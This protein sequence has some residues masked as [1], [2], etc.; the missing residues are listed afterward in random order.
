MISKIV[1]GLPLGGYTDKKI[2]KLRKKH[3]EISPVDIKKRYHEFKIETKV[4]RKIEKISHI[5]DG[6]F[7]DKFFYFMCNFAKFLKKVD[8]FEFNV[9]TEDMIIHATLKNFIE[10]HFYIFNEFYELPEKYFSYPISLYSKI[11]YASSFNYDTIFEKL[12]AENWELLKK[13]M[14][15]YYIVVAVLKYEFQSYKIPFHVVSNFF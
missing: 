3:I 13:Q 10:C 6:A 8:D 5:Y 9:D 2:G 7:V 12:L 11:F 15:K 1:A 14:P 4:I